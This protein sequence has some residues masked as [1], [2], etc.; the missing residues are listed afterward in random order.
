MR[1]KAE[2]LEKKGNRAVTIEKLYMMFSA[3]S[4]GVA[5]SI[6][7]YEIVSRELF[8]TSYDFLI[9]LPIWLTIWAALLATGPTL[10]EG[11]QVAVEFIRDKLKGKL[12][13]SI[14]VFNSLSVIVY[15]VLIT[16]GGVLMI[17]KY[18]AEGV[19]FSRYFRFPV[20]LVELCV[21]IGMLIFTIYAIGDLYRDFRR[22]R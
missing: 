4:L 2:K 1:E 10:K 14:D 5:V 3:A 7:M 9:S 15:S 6:T 8:H 21:P 16:W 19:A 11:G 17:R 13:L 12:Q 20:Y 22:K 18:Y